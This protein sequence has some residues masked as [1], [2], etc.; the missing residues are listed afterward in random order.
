MGALGAALGAAPVRA[1]ALLVA[2]AL[3]GA[4]CDARP[5][6]DPDGPGETI[7][8]DADGNPI[9]GEPGLGA[10]LPDEFTFELR[11]DADAMRAG[12]TELVP[13]TATLVDADRVTVPDE[14]ISWRASAGL[15]EQA[16]VATDESGAVT[17]TLRVPADVEADAIDV[18]VTAGGSSATLSV[19]VR[20]DGTA[21]QELSFALA[22]DLGRDGAAGAGADGNEGDGNDGGAPADGAVRFT[23]MLVDADRAPVPDREVR[24]SATDGVLRDAG[25][26]TDANGVSTATLLLPDGAPERDVT[27]SVESGAYRASATVP[28]GGEPDAELAFELASDAG[29]VALSATLVDAA[30]VPVAGRRVSWSASGGL[31]RDVATVTDDN[32]VAVASIVLPRVP[33]DTEIVVSVASERAGRSVRVLV[34]GDPDAVS[35]PTTRLG[36]E[37]SSDVGAGR[38]PSGG[39]VRLVATL[40][41]QARLPVADRAVAWRASDGVL[42][43]AV[44]V[45][46]ADGIATATLALPDVERDAD[47]VVTLASGL[48][49]RRLTVPVAGAAEPD[50]VAAGTLLFETFASATDVPTGT[51]GTVEIVATVTDADRV[52]VAGR[53]V[54]WRASAGVLQD[55][56]ATS[57]ANGTVSASLRLPQDY[58]NR[59]IEVEV[60][61]GDHA[62]VATV[63]T[64][65]TTLDVA[66]P[67]S[68]VFGD[69]VRLEIRLRDGLDRPIRDRAIDVVSR[70]GHAILPGSE[71]ATDA[72]GIATVT[73]AGL[74]ASD[75][76]TAS[77]FGAAPGMDATHAVAVSADRL[78]FDADPAAGPLERGLSVGAV[79][80]VAVTWTQNGAP[81]AGQPLRMT[82][83]TGE[84]VDGDTVPTDALGGATFRLRSASAGPARLTVED[85]VDGDP[86]ASADVEFTADVPAAVELHAA[87]TRVYT[88]DRAAVTAIVRDAGG[89]PVANRTVFFDSRDLRGGQLRPAAA[90]T[91]ASGRASVDFVAGEAATELDGVV[92]SARVEVADPAGPSAPG[93]TRDVRSRVDAALSVVERVLNVTLGAGNVITS[94][95][96]FTQYS[97]AFVVQVA[98]GSG[99]P[100]KG[101]GVALSIRPVEY[102]KGHLELV[103]ADGRPPEYYV[104]DPDAPEFSAE[105]WALATVDWAGR[106]AAEELADPELERDVFE[107]CAAEDA[108]R[109]RVRDFGEDLDGDGALDPQDPAVLAPGEAGAATLPGDGTLATDATGTGQFRMI[110][111]RSNALWSTVEITARARA[112]GTE[113]EDAFTIRLPM[114]DEEIVDTERGPSNRVSPYGTDAGARLGGDDRDGCR[115]PD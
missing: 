74:G 21:A 81:V 56:V 101:A 42:R 114:L 63:R 82:A 25:R 97:K 107:T 30:R 11:A 35:A 10:A 58:L 73:V 39:E 61:A 36:I 75:L 90:R 54:A 110:Y 68:A 16:G 95:A 18:T 17:A 88:G 76:I 31:F 59:D 92:V 41:D 64:H 2:A 106:R 46:G 45:T 108:N 9:G 71:V 66:G 67:D 77:A 103:D 104:G 20:G 62:S 22:S 14:P 52:P 55:V 27:V 12:R 38:A 115:S 83:T 48:V 94:E 69:D 80:E 3:L 60:A 51:A 40:V 109:N 32:G 79:H 7:A 47:V 29:A 1:A 50:A 84:V 91:D 78:T 4:G 85:A 93:G 111:P 26:M 28:A 99:A 89:N 49:E 33:G 86:S 13:I 19:P 8:L 102:H 24:W 6:D 72:D 112:L 5:G 98:D 43:D 70:E 113:A 23:A 34:A 105:R 37:L 44:A 53:E 15:I 65:G 96:P 100:V 87:P 57:D